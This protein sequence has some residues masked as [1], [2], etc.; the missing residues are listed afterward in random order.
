MVEV[1]QIFLLHKICFPDIAC[2]PRVFVM[3]FGCAKME[4]EKKVSEGEEGGKKVCF[5]PLSHFLHSLH[6]LHN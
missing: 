5:A 1:E 3:C 4:R 6:V 2:V